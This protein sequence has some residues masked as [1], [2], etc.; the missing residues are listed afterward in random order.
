[1]KDNPAYYKEALNRLSWKNKRAVS[2]GDSL[3]TD[4]YPAKL[5]GIKTVWVDRSNLNKEL[6]A[7]KTPWHTVNDLISAIDF[8]ESAF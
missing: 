3:N 1:M 4:I 6:N 8:I 2:I 7:E 5:V